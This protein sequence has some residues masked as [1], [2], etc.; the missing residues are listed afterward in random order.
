M[1]IFRCFFLL[2]LL[3]AFALNA[4]EQTENR[5][6]HYTLENGLEVVILPNNKAPV[7]Y[8]SL[9]YKV[10]SADSPEDK[11]GLAHFLEHLMFKGTTRFPNDTFKRTVT[12]LGGEQNANTSWDRTVYYVT[13][14]KE[15]LPVVMEMEADRM[16]QLSITD[17]IVDKEK[18]VVLQ[19]RRSVV[20]ARPEACLME[21]ANHA[22]FWEHPYGKPVI[23]YEED[24]RQYTKE[25]ALQFYQTWY[26]PNNAILVIAGDV[27]INTLKPLIQKFYGSLKGQKSPPRHYKSEPQHRS[28][29]ME[30]KIRDPQIGSVFFQR[31]YAAPN[32]RKNGLR[33]EAI[34]SLLQQLL[35]DDTFGRL[36]KSLVQQQKLAQTTTAQYIGYFYDPYSF[37][38]TG[39]P[40]NTTDLFLLEASIESE[41]RRLMNEGVLETELQI[42]KEQA[43]YHFQYRQDSI[44]G[45]AYLVGES[46]SVGYTLKDLD[47][48]PSIMQSISNDEIKAAAKSI[49]LSG[50]AVTAYG[51]PVAEK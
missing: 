31:L 49:F 26:T 5:Y 17:L 32:F 23:G 45:L 3:N 11:T 33:T 34:F 2:F 15:H 1:K 42:A 38:V 25:D 6:I 14:A 18:D 39:V 41:I 9:W 44:Q 43:N 19:E 20:D 21:A 29:T 22:F 7:V 28:A 40:T 30:V 27:E 47:D 12:D 4:K 37:T 16:Q 46:L 13:L 24:I 51:Y 48:W 10:G 8:H 50:P 35:G 36:S